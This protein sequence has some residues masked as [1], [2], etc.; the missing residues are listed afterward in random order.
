MN[1]KTV[2]Y[3]SFCKKKDMSVPNPTK[4]QLSPVRTLPLFEQFILQFISIIY[5]PVSITFL[6]N[7]LA[8]TEILIPEV[9]RLT[10]NELESTVNGLRKKGYLN[11]LNQC[12]PDWLNN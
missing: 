5:E 7:C 8:G 3:L 1:A 4:E 9:H 6:G 12:P 2:S 11:E 10:S